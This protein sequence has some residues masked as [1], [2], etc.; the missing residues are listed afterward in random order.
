VV[1]WHIFPVL[2]FCTKKIWQPCRKLESK[3]TAFFRRE[4]I[5]KMPAQLFTAH[6]GFKNVSLKQQTWRNKTTDWATRKG[7]KTS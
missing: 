5:S 1:V 6:W 3:S 7:Q 2:V 4:K